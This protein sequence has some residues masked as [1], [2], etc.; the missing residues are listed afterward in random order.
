MVNFTIKDKMVFLESDSKD[1][2][3]IPHIDSLGNTIANFGPPYSI[4]EGITMKISG[5]TATLSM[6]G[7]NGRFTVVK[8]PVDAILA[9]ASAIEEFSNNDSSINKETIE[10]IQLA[11]D[12]LNK[13]DA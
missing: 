8:V 2:P 10:E 1:N 4:I 9:L 5:K 13:E 6:S 7:K 11:I 3:I 12:E